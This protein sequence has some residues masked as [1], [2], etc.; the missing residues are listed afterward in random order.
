MGIMLVKPDYFYKWYNYFYYTPKVIK[1]AYY[2]TYI[3]F[4]NIL[5]VTIVLLKPLWTRF[6][7]CV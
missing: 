5:R 2:K 3:H 4:Y 1:D 7:T 6:L